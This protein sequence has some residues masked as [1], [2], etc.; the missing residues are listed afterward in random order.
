MVARIPLV[1]ISG[2]VREL[3]A[4][5]NVYDSW[6]LSKDRDT[7]TLLSKTL[8]A[9]HTYLTGGAGA[10][11]AMTLPAASS[12]LDGRIYSVMSSNL[13]LLTSWVSS[14]ASFVG[15][16]GTMGALVPYSFQYDHAST[17]WFLC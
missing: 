16:P 9:R 12:S 1:M 8:S 3:P 6:Q 7:A 14:G 4:G 17:T 2:Q 10:T 15:A 11:M 13:R 5:D